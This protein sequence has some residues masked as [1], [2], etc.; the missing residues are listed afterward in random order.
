MTKMNDIIFKI[1][2]RYLYEKGLFIDKKQIKRMM[3]SHESYPSLL[4]LTDTLSDLGIDYA[5][6]K[7][8]SDRLKEFD[9]PVMLH[10]GRGVNQFILLTKMSK[11][12]VFYYDGQKKKENIDWLLDIWDGVAVYIFEKKTKYDFHFLLTRLTKMKSIFFL[13]GLFLFVTLPFL[14]ILVRI[15][16]LFLLVLKVIGFCMSIL[17]IRHDLGI[18]STL[19]QHICSFSN[20]ISCEAVLT[21]PASKFLGIF[22]MSDIAVVYFTCSTFVLLY[23]LLVGMLNNYITI[24]SFISLFS[25]PYILYSLFYQKFKVK[26]WCPLCLCVI[27]IL[28]VEVLYS[29]WWI[30]LS[31]ITISITQIL[32]IVL[33]VL[34]VIIIWI[35][36]K[37]LIMNNIEL[38]EKEIKYLRMKHDTQ[39]FQALLERQL[40][41]KM[42]FSPSDIVLGE[43]N[44]Q[45]VITIVI[46]VYCE[47]CLALYKQLK[48][49]YLQTGHKFKLNIRMLNRETDISGKSTESLLIALYYEDPSRFI[50][51]FDDWM[52]GK[53]YQFLCSKYYLNMN[54]S[55]VNQELNRHREWIERIGIDVTPQIFVNDRLIPYQYTNDDLFYFLRHLR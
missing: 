49:I 10:L 15:S 9:A 26:K 46:N 2:T 30:N 39:I 21:S 48:S 44:A 7:M 41:V 3:C 33:I 17:L 43:L 20:S 8:N 14:L 37:S 52:S 4:A 50:L 27:F 32:F 36:I 1:S 51:A 28:F 53:N 54:V 31:I 55:K 13:V 45:T 16:V 12:K 11:N 24:L 40:P 22:K 38:E 18:S 25:I 42:D 5:A 23:S 35:L 6:V 47:P 19:E 34:I 29:L